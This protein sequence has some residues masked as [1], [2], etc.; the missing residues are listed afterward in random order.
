MEQ[1]G[2]RIMPNNHFRPRTA[3]SLATPARICAFETLKLAMDKSLFVSQAFDRVMEGKK[4]KPE[5]KAFSRLLSVGTTGTVGVLDELINRVLSSPRDIKMDVRIALRIST[6]ELFFLKKSSH[7]AV[8]Q[9]V[10]L[11]RYVSSHATGLANY[12][13]RRLSDLQIG[14]PFGDSEESFDV[15]IYEQGF[16]LWLGQRLKKDL[17]KRNALSI[18]KEANEPAPL[19]MMVNA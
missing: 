7:A 19:Y 12:A 8:D 9:G 13:L 16:P 6:Y 2:G 5:E 14:F 15:A 4:L 17:G 3:K 1:I 10:E 11:V 18:M